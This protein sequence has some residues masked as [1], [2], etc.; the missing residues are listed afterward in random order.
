MADE[1][2]VLGSEL[3]RADAAL[4]AVVVDE[5]M[6][7][8]L[9]GVASELR[10][11][12]QRVGRCF[13][14]KTLRQRLRT[15]RLEV[16]F[17]P[18]EHRQT[19]LPTELGACHKIQPRLTCLPFDSIELADV[20]H[21]R[22]QQFAAVLDCLHDVAAQMRH[23][24]HVPD[25][26]VGDKAVVHLVAIRLQHATPG[27]GKKVLQVATP[28]RQIEVEHDR[29]LVRGEIRPE[30][31][32]CGV[33]ATIRIH[34]PDRRLVHLNVATSEHSFALLPVYGP[35][36]ERGFFDAAGLLLTRQ[37]HIDARRSAPSG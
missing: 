37:L 35:E 36:Q 30:V 20:E 12:V 25:R 5:H 9:I 34:H 32:L 21:Q 22:R 14:E 8:V 18:L 23:A 27:A 3:G 28:S 24:S 33:T 7:H 16:R 13:S 29:V 4:D 11:L 15:R 19:A 17:Q 1:V 2:P 31:R 6:A 10:P 26:L